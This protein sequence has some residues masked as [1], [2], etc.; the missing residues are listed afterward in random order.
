MQITAHPACISQPVCPPGYQRCQR[1]MGCKVLQSPLR[2]LLRTETRE[3]GRRKI[4]HPPAPSICA[5][6]RQHRL[7]DAVE[8]GVPISKPKT[9]GQA[10]AKS[11]QAVL[12]TSPAIRPQSAKPGSQPP[13]LVMLQHSMLPQR[14]KCPMDQLVLGSCLQY[15]GRCRQAAGERGYKTSERGAGG[16]ERSALGRSSSSDAFRYTVLT[17]T[18]RLYKDACT[19]YFQIG[20]GLC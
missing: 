11:L 8:A 9:R 13:R 18:V 10:R 17:R 19:L 20:P 4:S 16:R 1:K 5:S 6:L 15:S 7:E 12:F 14:S 3:T 2:R